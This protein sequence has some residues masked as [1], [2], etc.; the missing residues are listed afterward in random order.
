MANPTAVFESTEGTFKAEIYEQQMP[1][2]AANFIALIERGFYDGIYFHRVI[3]G[4]MCQFG[5]DRSRTPNAPGAG[6]GSSP[7]GNVRDEHNADA[8]F[9]NE[10][11]TLSMANTGRPNSGGA[12]FFINTAHNSYLDWWD[13]RTPSQHPVFG[14]IT[15]GWDV[16]KRIE[17]LGSR[18]GT[19]SKPV[20]VT[21]VTIVRA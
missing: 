15:E 17:G 19:M 14:K 2:T 4:F 6:T 9:S 20:Q 11:G 16:I 21:K 3:P 7:L 10:P 8:K 1:V 5:C 18:S 12:Q 13:T